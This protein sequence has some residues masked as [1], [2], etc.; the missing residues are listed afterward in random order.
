MSERVEHRGTITSANGFEWDWEC[1]CDASG[2]Q[3]M[4]IDPRGRAVTAYQE[5]VYAAMGRE[6]VEL[7]AGVDEIIAVRLAPPTVSD[8]AWLRMANELTPFLARQRAALEVEG[9]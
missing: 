8:P 5:H 4:G 2:V 7:L 1:V 3:I 9:A 6:A